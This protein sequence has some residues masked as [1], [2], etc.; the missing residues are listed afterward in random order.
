MIQS[1]SYPAKLDSEDRTLNVSFRDI[2]EA[3]TFGDSI[4]DALV[5]AADCLDEAIAGRIDDKQD[6][7]LP[8]APESGEYPI[9]VPSLTAMKAHIYL[10]LG[11]QG[12][13]KT[14]LAIRLNVDPKE[15]RRIVDPRHKTKLETLERALK[16]LGKRLVVAV[17]SDAA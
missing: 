10:A 1:F 12:L 3:L 13:S 2:P 14:D 11:E 6:I 5:Q 16:A 9:A 17:E 15:A 4:E 8:S 7:P